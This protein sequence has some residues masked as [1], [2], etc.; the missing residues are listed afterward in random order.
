MWEMLSDGVVLLML[1]ADSE[2][3]L[4]EFGKPFSLLRKILV[5]LP[6]AVLSNTVNTRMNW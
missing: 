4:P 1:Y 2:Y 5:P 6:N 3:S